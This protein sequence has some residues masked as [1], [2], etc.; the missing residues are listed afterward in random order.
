MALGWAP[1]IRQG[2][3]LFMLIIVDYTGVVVPS[4]VTIKSPRTNPTLPGISW[5]SAASRPLFPCYSAVETGSLDLLSVFTK[6][7][8]RASNYS[9]VH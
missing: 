3:L 6:Q 7:F 8:A 2:K 5:A 1:A 4:N 9:S